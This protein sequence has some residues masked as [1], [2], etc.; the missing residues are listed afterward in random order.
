MFRRKLIRRDAASELPVDHLGF[1]ASQARDVGDGI[2]A[3]KRIFRNVRGMDSKMV[4][5]LQEQIAAT[6][7]GGGEDQHDGIM[8][9]PA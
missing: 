2:F 7:R 4:A 9:G 5:G 3:G 1:F 8:A 6:G